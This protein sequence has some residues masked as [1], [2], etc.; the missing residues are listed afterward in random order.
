MAT[1]AQE[2]AEDLLKYYQGMGGTARQPSALSSREE[3][4]AFQAQ[5]VRAGR[6]PAETLPEDYGGRPQ[7]ESRRSIRMQEAY[8]ARQVESLQQQRIMQEMERSAKIEQREGWRYT[9]EQ[10]EY[11]AQLKLDALNERDAAQESSEVN[12]IAS[13][14]EGIDL[15]NDP[16]AGLKI[17]QLV[18]EN[19]LGAARDTVAKRLEAARNI[20]GTYG[21]AAT[22]KADQEAGKVKS[23]I[24]NKALSEGVTESEIEATRF[25]DP[26]TA[27]VDYDYE[28]IER[29]AAKRGGERKDK[30]PEE[31]YKP[32][33]VV[34]ARDR[35]DVVKAEFDALSSSVEGG[36]LEDD[37]PDY[38]KT[39]ARLR[40]AEAE[41]KVAEG[42]KR[43][44]AGG[45][46][47]EPKELNPRDKSALDWANANP[48]DPRSSK[49]KQ[50]LGVD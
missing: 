6:A 36:E 33:S 25:A 21:I 43:P 37:D 34:E 4:R 12:A 45:A 13:G 9:K 14:L 46:Q 48:D 49:I 17:D 30:E 44:Q 19:P 50:R 10:N 38:V 28:K 23:A 2:Q 47:P 8:D 40:K 31:E 41:L 1:Y 39:R 35:R 22:T 42:A 15:K 18:L 7:G 11:S 5:E 3:Q 26:K 29:L 20:S 27:M 16:E 24:I 32:I